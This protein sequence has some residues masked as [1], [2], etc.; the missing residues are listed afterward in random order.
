MTFPHSS[1]ALNGGKFDYC[2]LGMSVDSRI[3]SDFNATP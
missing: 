3:G 1:Q 2:R